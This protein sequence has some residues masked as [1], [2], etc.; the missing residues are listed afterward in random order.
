[1]SATVLIRVAERFAHQANHH[2]MV[3]AIRESEEGITYDLRM[4]ESSTPPGYMRFGDL[5][6]GVIQDLKA[7][8]HIL[9]RVWSDQLDLLHVSDELSMGTRRMRLGSPS[10]A[11]ARRHHELDIVDET[12]KEQDVIYIAEIPSETE[13][14]ELNASVQLTK[15]REG[16]STLRHL[17]T[18]EVEDT[19]QEEEEGEEEGEGDGAAAAGPSGGPRFQ[20]CLICM[21]L[22]KMFGVLPCYHRFWYVAVIEVSFLHVAMLPLF[23]IRACFALNGI[24]SFSQFILP[25]ANGRRQQG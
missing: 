11:P 23:L 9:R 18:M 8:V 21:E 20:R 2:G 24:V 19:L 14:A 4:R 6:L 10:S 3:Y 1:M 16:L 17:K 12:E 13:A 5:L 25:R 7:E 15:L 22:R